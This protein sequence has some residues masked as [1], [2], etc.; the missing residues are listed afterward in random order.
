VQHLVVMAA[1][2]ALVLM[3]GGCAAGPR[4]GEADYVLGY[5]KTGPE[6]AKKT[7]DESAAIFAGHMSNMK[8]MAERGELVIAGPF[9]TPADKSW[10]GIFV[11]DRSDVGEAERLMATDPG[12]VAGVFVGE[13]RSMRASTALREAKRLEDEANAGRV[14]EAGKPPANIRGYVMVTAE[15]AERCAAALASAGYGERVV[16]CGRFLDRG[17]KG[18]VFVLDA[19]DAGAVRAELE[20]AGTGVCA[21][22]A[23]WSTTSIV[24][25]PAGAKVMPRR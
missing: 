14:M 24:G 18:G 25:L 21:V 13:R 10:R 6:S 7:K 3:V 12:I 15:E 20:K 11:L 1:L 22:D 19:E 9:N 5:L 23:W 4:S 17:G 8:A 2:A 16:W